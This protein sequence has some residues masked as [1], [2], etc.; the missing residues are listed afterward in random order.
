MGARDILKS[1]PWIGWAFSLLF[2]GLALLMYVRGSGGNAPD[3]L[4]RRSQM[5]TI[6]CTETGNEW[7][8]NRGQFERL[9]MTQ[10]GMLDPALGIPSE[11]AE[12]RLT[13]V[14]VDK[15][16]WEETV[17]RINAMKKAYGGG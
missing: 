1:K 10:S 6:R 8:M 4:E 13:G 9:L 11:F 5:V 14:L 7:Q 3:S 12:G 2:L 16:D 17:G 15:D